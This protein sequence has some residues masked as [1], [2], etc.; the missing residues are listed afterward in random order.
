MALL[1]LVFLA[2]GLW[3]EAYLPGMGAVDTQ[4]NDFETL[5]SITWVKQLFVAYNL[6]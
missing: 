4:I 1:A 2:L 6:F 5:G 3:A